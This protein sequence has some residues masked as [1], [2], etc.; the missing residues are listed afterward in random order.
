MVTEGLGALEGPPADTGGAPL[1][2]ERPLGLPPPPKAG[3]LLEL[4]LAKG[5]MAPLPIGKSS[6]ETQVVTKDTVKL[7]D[8]DNHPTHLAGQVHLS[9][10]WVESFPSDS[11]PPYPE[12]GTSAYNLS[13]GFYTSKV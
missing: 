1:P 12:R 6:T 11:D 10:D 13:F 9:S 3:V 4:L 2:G 7:S 8:K 5:C